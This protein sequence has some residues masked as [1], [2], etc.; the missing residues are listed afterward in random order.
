MKKL[1]SLLL[2]LVLLLALGAPALAAGAAVTVDYVGVFDY[3]AAYAILDI[4]N[5]ERST[6]GLSALR[7]DEELLETAM[8]RAAECAVFYSHTRPNGENLSSLLSNKDTLVLGENIAYGQNS[9]Q[10]VMSAWMS[11]EGHQAN[12]L[13]NNYSS[14]GIGCF[15]QYGD[16]YWTQVFSSDQATEPEV[17]ETDVYVISVDILPSNVSSLTSGDGPY[18]A[19]MGDLSYIPFLLNGVM[20][21]PSC[22][23]IDIEDTSVLEHHGDG[24][25]VGIGLGTTMVY[26][27]F[28]GFNKSFS[29]PVTTVFFDDVPE[30]EWYFDSVVYAYY[31]EIFNGTS[32]TTFAP[33]DTMSRGM[34]CQVIYNLMGWYETE[35][36]DIPDV[37]YDMWY[38]DAVNWAVINNIDADY[39]GGNFRPNDPITR[40]QLFTMMGQLCEFSEIKLPVTREKPA[41]EDAADISGWAKEHIESLYQ[42][43]VINGKDG[44]LADPKGTATRAEV[45]TVFYNFLELEVE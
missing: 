4:V 6:R 7:M 32:E 35:R 36:A 28:E 2:A 43:G 23:I 45:A 42:A 21:E 17:E 3:D 27:F 10:E 38:S 1:T 31:N 5:A 9:A 20:L 26:A 14:I 22:Y 11:S 29:V 13:G 8:F 15:Y 16:I 12:I 30:G 44:N 33:L 37:A 34:A 18:S 19:F 24:T 41:F 25:F 39:D 40:E